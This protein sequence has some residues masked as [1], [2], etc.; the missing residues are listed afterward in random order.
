MQC[1]GTVSG[2]A[3]GHLEAQGERACSL[4]E[5]SAPRV[6]QGMGRHPRTLHSSIS[7]NPQDV[8]LPGSFSFGVSGWLGIRVPPEVLALE[9]YEL[10]TLKLRVS[11]TLNPKLM[12]PKTLN[13][14]P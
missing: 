3:L 14:K 11:K 2:L 1:L 10:W 9:F 8:R 13:P 7:I 12:K 4:P 6:L 5:V